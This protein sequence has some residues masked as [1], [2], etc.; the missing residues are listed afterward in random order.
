MAVGSL[1]R[2]ALGDAGNAE[3]DQDA[4]PNDLPQ[5]RSNGREREVIS[6]FAFDARAWESY[7]ATSAGC[8]LPG[9]HPSKQQQTAK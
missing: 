6:P 8:Y 7:W 1:P 3:A 4:K 9:C 2:Y 5:D